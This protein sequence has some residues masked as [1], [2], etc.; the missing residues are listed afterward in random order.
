MNATHT[1]TVEANK[2]SPGEDKKPGFRTKTIAMRLTPDELAEVES[3]AE[4]AGKPISEWLRE[5]ALTAARK[6]PADPVELILAEL[7]A[8]R[9]GLLNLFYAGAQAT[10]QG[11]AMT[12]ESILKIRDRTDARKLDEARKMLGKFLT[13]ETRSG[14]DRS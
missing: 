8:V 3:A 1:T 9:H 4:Q 13:P 5:T 7:W 2:P 10:A 12:P 14:G 11:A 6:R